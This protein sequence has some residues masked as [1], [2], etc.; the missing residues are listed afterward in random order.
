MQTQQVFQIKNWPPKYTMSIFRIAAGELVPVPFRPSRQNK[1]RE[2]SRGAEDL[3]NKIK[4]LESN[5]QYV[6]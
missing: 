4:D 2:I 5:P 6:L 1:W 3:D